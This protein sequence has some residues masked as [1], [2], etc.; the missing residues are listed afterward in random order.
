MILAEQSSLRFEQHKFDKR[1]YVISSQQDLLTAQFIRVLNVMGLNIE[2]TN[3]GLALSISMRKVTAVFLEQII[4]EA[5]SVMYEQMKKSQ[6][7]MLQ[8]RTRSRPVR[9]WPHCDQ[10][11]G[12]G[13]PSGSQ[14]FLS[15]SQ[16]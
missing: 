11:P 7:S 8:S 12:H 14:R 2:H 1:I 9:G 10:N 4:R 3:Y 13:S 6:E 5:A 15:L 16:N